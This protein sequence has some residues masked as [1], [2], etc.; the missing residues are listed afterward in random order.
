M[1]RRGFLKSAVILTGGVLSLENWLAAA[2]SDTQGRR[3]DYAA[4]KG[5]ARSLAEQS[6]KPPDKDLPESLADLNWD[7]VQA[8][9]FR[10]A[11]ALWYSTPSRFRVQ[12]FHRTPLFKDRVRLAEIVKG[13]AREIEY[14]PAMFDFSKAGVQTRSLK[15]DLGFAGFRLHFDTD[16]QR[17]IA[18]FLGASYFRAV[19]TDNHQY[20]L[21]ARGLAID[22]ALESGEEFPIFTE[23]WLQRP[24]GNADSVTIYSL[25]DSPSVTGAYRFEIAPGPTTVMEID[26]ALYPRKPIERLGIAPLT[27][28][29]HYGKNDRRLAND[30][31][32]EVHDSDGLSI[33][34]GS[35][36]W[37]WR[38]LVNSTGV[39]VNSFIDEKPRGFG[40][41]QRDRD[42]DHY[43]DDGAYYDRRPSLWVE[44]KLGSPGWE[45]GAIQLVELPA[46]D[47][48]FD[49]IVAFWNPADKPQPGQELLFSYRLHWGIRMPL[50]P[51]LAQVVATRTGTG[52]VVGQKRKHFSWRF[53][54]DFVGGELEGLPVKAKVEPVITASRGEVEIA[55]ARPQKEIKGY[56]AM[57]DLKPSD[58]SIEPIDLRLYLRLGGQPLTETWL[59]QWTPPPPSE[60][61][62]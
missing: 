62:F 35:G 50:A 1:N 24:E 52:G 58:S 45:K 21:S 8:I 33:L 3:F 31:R 26:A 11:R 54:V 39:R 44:P 46:V 60:R 43:Q 4:L 55:S 32:P 15:K 18:A 61:N 48:T 51:A 14:D 13:T 59:Y 17:D 29:Y 28:M 2:R 6:Y 30:W 19:S 27:S 36:E 56:R 16:W 5:H 7:A 25:L 38:P 53:V 20:G 9:R 47:E 57:F 41:L 42:F 22:T 23:F 37:I 49:N 34:T 12:F 40:L 10:S